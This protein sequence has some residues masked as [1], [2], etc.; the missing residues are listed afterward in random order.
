MPSPK[1][2]KF[3]Q[4]ILDI[5]LQN[6][7]PFMI[8]GTYAFTAYTGIYRATKDLD[9][10]T[11]KS[12]CLKVLA[13]L[14]KKGFAAE[15]LNP[16]WIGKVYH[17]EDF[18]DIIFA[19][20]NDSYH[21]TSEWFGL[22]RTSRIFDRDILLMPVEYMISTKAYV[23]FR[24]KYD[25]SDITYLL[26][27]YADTLDWKILTHHL[28]KHWQLLFAHLL[29]FTFVFP[30]ESHHIPSWVMQEYKKMIQQLITHPP[31]QGKII[32]GHLISYEYAC[33]IKEWK[34]NPIRAL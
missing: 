13:L 8:G 21:V 25:G 15:L 2:E 31:P 1:T 9:I 18:I 22:T 34:Y 24:D 6:N 4:D 26:L 19:E 10:I 12:N 11:T 28:K 20:R 5:F 23:Q 33:A 29:L 30:S 32:Q 14:R 17:D 16:V 3:Y 7:I 27:K